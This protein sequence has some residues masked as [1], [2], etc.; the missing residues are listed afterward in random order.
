M[1]HRY[2]DLLSKFDI[3]WESCI[4]EFPN[5]EYHSWQSCAPCL[6]ISRNGWAQKG[7]YIRLQYIQFSHVHELNLLGVHYTWNTWASTRMIRNQVSQKSFIKFCK[8]LILFKIH[9]QCRGKCIDRSQKFSQAR[10]LTTL[11]MYTEGPIRHT[12]EHAEIDCWKQDTHIWIFTLQS[13]V[14]YTTDTNRLSLQSH[15]S[16]IMRHW[17]I[18]LPNRQPDNWMAWQWAE[19]LVEIRGTLADIRGT[20]K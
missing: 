20:T 10:Q 16:L 14:T 13:C 17:K 6:Q 2:D 19:T 1:G 8:K 12:A 5:W 3:A 4:A 7:V 9:T 11:K 18:L 15:Q